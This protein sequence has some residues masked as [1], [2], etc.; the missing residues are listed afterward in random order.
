M[1][2]TEKYPIVD[3]FYTLQGEGFHMGK[4]AFFVRIGGCDIGCYWCDTKYK[5]NPD[6][7][8]EYSAEQLFEK[9]SVHKS[10]S[11]VV[12]GGEPTLYNLEPITSVF[13][14]NSFKT[15]LETSGN[16]KLT[17][18]WDWI[19]LS[20]KE[21]NPPTKEMYKK[22]NELKVIIYNEEDLR[23]AEKA[24]ENVNKDCLLYLQAEWSRFNENIDMITD[25]IK[26]NIKWK[27]SL[28]AHKF[29]NIP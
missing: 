21:N 1:L 8:K 24:A 10:K 11:L 29:M 6:I 19:C 17:G 9:A 22:A 2:K 4:A 12:T 13:R 14:K 20:P 15:F 7:D 27:I 26:K 5:W 28:Q 3:S 23:W 25:Y 16:H 18:E